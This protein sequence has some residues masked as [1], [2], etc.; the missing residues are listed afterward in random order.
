MLAPRRLEEMQFAVVDLETTGISPHLHD[1]VVEVGIVRM[2][3]APQGG[4]E[5]TDEFVTLV[6]PGRDIGPTRIHGITAAEVTEAPQFSDVSGDIAARLDDAVIAAHNLRF[7][8]TFLKAEFA[9][10]G[11]TMPELPGV[12]TLGLA[13]RIHSGLPSRKLAHLCEEA[14]IEHEEGHSALEDA[15]ATAHLLGHYLTEASRRGWRTCGEIGCVWC[16]IPEVRTWAPPCSGRL[17]SRSAA[18]Q[19]LRDERGYLARLVERL[20]PASVATDPSSAAYL[21]ILD[22][23]LEDRLVSDREADSLLNFAVSEGLTRGE[24]L[25]LHREYLAS[26][27]GAARYDG[28]ISEAE[29]RDLEVVCELLGLHRAVVA[30]VLGAESKVLPLRAEAAASLRGKS[31]CFTGEMASSWEGSSITREVAERL[32]TD[33]GLIVARS[34]TKRLDMLV[35]ADPRTS[36]GKAEKARRYGTRIVAEQAFWQAIGVSVD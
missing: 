7:D 34:V 29:Q 36:S 26:L 9:R 19:R 27:A 8:V 17:L 11:F 22:R 23:A 24:V 33:A 15:R 21:A 25:D 13:C 31:V 6:N 3:R 28:D 5:V 10:A 12:C 4:W 18:S 20:P 30:H 14:G 1:R 32:A 16:E 35:V 2:A